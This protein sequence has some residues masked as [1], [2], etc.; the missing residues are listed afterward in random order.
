M[1]ACAQPQKEVHWRC[2]QEAWAE[3]EETLLPTEGVARAQGAT[4]MT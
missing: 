2:I 1:G 4:G 3:R